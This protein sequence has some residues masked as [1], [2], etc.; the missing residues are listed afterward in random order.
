MCVAGTIDGPASSVK[1]AMLT[2]DTY[3]FAVAAQATPKGELYNPETAPKPSSSGRL[4]TTTFVRHWDTWITPNRNSI[5]FGKLSKQEGC[6]YKLSELTN[7]L[8][9]TGL[10]SPVPPFGGSDNYDL[11]VSGIIFVAK[12][13]TINA[14]LNTKMNFYYIPISDFEASEVPEPLLVPT[15]NLEGAATSPSFSPDGK[16]AAFLKMRQNGYEADKNQL[17]VIP[18]I[19]RPG[20][21]VNVFTTPDGKGSWDRSPQSVSWSDN[22]RI[23][24]M[25]A[26]DSGRSCMWTLSIDSLA[27][28]T[29]PMR[30]KSIG[31]ITD[32]RPLKDDRALLS[33]SSLVDNSTYYLYDARSYPYG[34]KVISS[35]SH[36]GSTLGLSP[37]QVDQIWWPGSKPGTFVHAWIVKPSRFNQH[38]KYPLAYAI[39]GG[40]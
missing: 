24:Y 29:L 3:A 9:G 34:A 6:R 14:A 10:E 2:K 7:A 12:D 8:Q 26:E 11:S 15:G 4:Y 33:G 22:G 21:I 31:S 38:E 13:P 40:N 5:W 16:K 19:K 1:L 17:L 28:P 37:K 27:E 39:H 18:D 23:L 36:N 20:W 25:T 30:V 35:H 32:I